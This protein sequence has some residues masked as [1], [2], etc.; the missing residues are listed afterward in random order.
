MKWITNIELLTHKISAYYNRIPRVLRN[1]YC[2]TVVGFFVF[3]LFFDTNNIMMQISL[4]RELNGI[5]N[6]VEQ[7]NKEYEADKKLLEEIKRDRSILQK[8]GRER[9][10][11]HYE[12]E[13]VYYFK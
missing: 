11:M 5:H 9:Y 3:V 12:N 10:L 8:I 2:I 4:Q 1:K 6:E 7:Y 13:D